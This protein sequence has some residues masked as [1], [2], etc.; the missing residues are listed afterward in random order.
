MSLF[1]IMKSLPS[2]NHIIKANYKILSSSH[3]NSTT[4]LLNTDDSI[5]GLTTPN[6]VAVAVLTFDISFLVSRTG[7]TVICRRWHRWEKNSINH[8]N[9]TVGGQY[10]SAHDHCGVDE[11]ILPFDC[12]FDFG[13]LE[14]FS[15]HSIF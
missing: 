15:H 6:E 1:R 12:H 8:V 7:D 5:R 10:I 14:S 3:P 13:P 4:S 11:N 9:D 2:S